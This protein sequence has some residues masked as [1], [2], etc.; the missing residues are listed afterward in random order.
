MAE[1]GGGATL[2][3]AKANAGINTIDAGRTDSL[4]LMETPLK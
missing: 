4:F 3:C 2:T 1:A